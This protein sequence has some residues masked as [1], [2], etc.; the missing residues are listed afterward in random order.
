MDPVQDYQSYAAH[1]HEKAHD[2]KQS[3]LRGRN[4][5]IIILVLFSAVSQDLSI[6]V[7]SY[8]DLLDRLHR[9]FLHQFDVEGGGQDE[10]Q[11]SGSRRTCRRTQ[12]LSHTHTHAA[13][14]AID[15]ITSCLHL[16]MNPK[17]SLMVG[18]KMTRMLTE[19]R[20]TTV[21]PMC[22]AQLKSLDAPISWLT[23]VR[24]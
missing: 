7:L 14:H 13:E 20:R 19:T 8:P 11:H 18:T 12:H 21:M 16:P 3:C 1:H 10:D 5:C 4:D 24:I 2:Q 15:D 22:R 17:M 9:L 23:E 6:C